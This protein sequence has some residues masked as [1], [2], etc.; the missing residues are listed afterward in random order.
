M[1]QS[2]SLGLSGSNTRETTQRMDTGRF[3]QRLWG[4]DVTLWKDD[5]EHQKIIAR[6]LG[7]LTVP[8][9]LLE[10]APELSAFAEEI[11]EDG[12]T[13][14]LVMGMGGSS[15]GPE[16]LRQTLV[17][18][19]G[20]PELIVLDSTVPTCVQSVTDAFDPPRTLF[21]VSS[22]SGTTVAPNTLYS[23]L[24]GLVQQAVVA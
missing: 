9:K 19:A 11:R 4:R 3:M 13:H 17:S 10:E 8:E 18:A 12:F 2:F 24:R 15:L 6:S 21:L 20:Y 7:W 14:L 5:P 22:K 23:Y 16:V 1:K